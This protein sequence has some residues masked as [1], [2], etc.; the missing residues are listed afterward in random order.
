M[1]LVKPAIIEIALDG[2]IEM[3]AMLI[4]PKLVGNDELLRRRMGQS[5][6]LR[7]FRTVLP[8]GP[9]SCEKV[10]FQSGFFV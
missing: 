1:L 9:R 6:E 5:S 10:Q 8:T 2:P 4:L 3:F 7:R